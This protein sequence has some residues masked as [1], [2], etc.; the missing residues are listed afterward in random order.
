M[1][2][3]TA[4]R[5]IASGPSAAVVAAVCGAEILGMAGYSTVPALLPQFIADWSLSNAEGGWLAGMVFAGYMLGVLPLVGLTDRLPA[6]RIYLAAST[7]SALSCFGV[8][9]SDSLLPALVFRALAG[10]A[11]AG[12]YMPGL[13]VLIAGVEGARRS[14]IAAFYTSAFTIGAALSFLFGRTGMLWGWRS[15]FYLAGILGAAG[16][17]IAWKALPRPAAGAASTPRRMPGFRPVFGNRDALVLIF[18]YA[19][20]I[21]GSAGLR[22]WIVVFLAFCAGAPHGDAAQGWSMLAVGALINFLG[23]P[24]GLLGDELALRF[25]L[26]GT[27][28]LVF[29]LSALTSG[30][31]GLAATLPYGAVVTLSLAAGFIAQGNFSNLTS[32]VLA[33]AEPSHAGATVALY[34]CVGLA[35]GFSALSSSASCSM[36]S[37]ARRG[38]WPGR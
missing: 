34:S 7:L 38:P 19:A 32:G 16:V 6:R 23:V 4:A 3:E 13:R 29:L 30:V 24:A 1:T 17:A 8:A 20:A 2:A 12:M 18:A 9:L 10:I 35:A 33:V 37:A 14:R 26:R 11:L 5:G 25:G 36:R 28:V 31:F 27:A 15:A 21:W 22:Q